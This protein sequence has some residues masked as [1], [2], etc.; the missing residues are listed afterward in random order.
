M[1]IDEAGNG[2]MMLRVRKIDEKRIQNGNAKFCALALEQYAK[3]LV[4]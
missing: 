3:L 4:P 2:K 1:I